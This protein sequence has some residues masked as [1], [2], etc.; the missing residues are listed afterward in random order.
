MRDCDCW[1]DSIKKKYNGHQQ[2][3]T[4]QKVRSE[5]EDHTNVQ[6]SANNQWNLTGWC[7]YVV[8][9]KEECKGTEVRWRKKG[10]K[11]TLN[12]NTMKHIDNNEAVMF[13]HQNLQ[14]V[15]H[16]N[17][18]QMGHARLHEDVRNWKQYFLVPLVMRAFQTMVQMEIWIFGSH[19]TWV[20]WEADKLTNWYP[21]CDLVISSHLNLKTEI[22]Q[23]KEKIKSDQN[24]RSCIADIEFALPCPVD[25][26]MQA[27]KLW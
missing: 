13:A 22:E 27:L 12:A 26:S 8:R 25:G 11:T 20:N 24:V 2:K 5:L 10:I 4:V 7:G 21:L 3:E 17:N 1:D 18:F 6:E 23:T 9:R 15:N 14:D 19:T 16:W